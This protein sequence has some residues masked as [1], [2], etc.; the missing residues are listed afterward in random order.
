MK[1]Y[2]RNMDFWGSTASLACAIHCALLPLLFSFGL[3]GS[4]HWFANPW[5]E[6]VMLLVTSWFIYN[7][8]IKGYLTGSTSK[9]VFYLAL[10]GLVLLLLHHFLGQYSTIVVVFGG[11]LV[12]VAHLLNLKNHMHAST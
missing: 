5:V 8:L 3:M 9:A 12:A 11:V 6:I 10:F 4:H 1:N 2:L 7:S